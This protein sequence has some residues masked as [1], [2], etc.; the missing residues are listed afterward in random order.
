MGTWDAGAGG[1]AATE[2]GTTAAE[3]E[4][5]ALSRD[6]RRPSIDC[7]VD[8]R[9]S[10]LEERSSPGGLEAGTGRGATASESRSS[11]RRDFLERFR[12]GVATEQEAMG[13]GTRSGKTESASTARA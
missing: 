11:G 13:D 10:R 5:P 2:E 4:A 3:V 12:P 9:T 7:K 8:A 1:G 6:H